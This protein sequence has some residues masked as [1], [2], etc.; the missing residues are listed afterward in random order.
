MTKGSC[1]HASSRKW[2]TTLLDQTWPLKLLRDGQTRLSTARQGGFFSSSLPVQLSP[3]ANGTC[4]RGILSFWELHFLAIPISHS[5][6]MGSHFRGNEPNS[7]GNQERHRSRPDVRRW[8]A[9]RMNVL[10]AG[11]LS[12]SIG[13]VLKPFLLLSCG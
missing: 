13:L 8:M 4:G 12:L 10:F 9:C 6:F 1:C 2:L 11:N 5:A 7:Q 3:F